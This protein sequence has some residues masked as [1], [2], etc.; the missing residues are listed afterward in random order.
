MGRPT[1]IFDWERLDQICQLNASLLDA[2]EMLKVG[3]DTIRRYIREKHD[4]TFSEYRDKRM[5]N[6]RLTLVQK[7]LQM[8]KAGDRVMLIFCLKNLN[9]WADKQEVITSGDVT[10]QIQEQDGKL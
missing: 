8:A 5:S 2:S 1:V 4:C 3:P 10:L 7:A 6:V 9:K